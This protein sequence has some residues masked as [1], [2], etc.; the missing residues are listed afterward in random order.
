MVKRD[1]MSKA[2]R[3]YGYSPTTVNKKLLEGWTP[4]QALGLKKRKGHHPNTAGIIYLIK[5]K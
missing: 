5:N 4:E 3:H 2:A 1:T